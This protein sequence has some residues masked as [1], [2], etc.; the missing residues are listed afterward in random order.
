MLDELKQYISSCGYENIVTGTL[1][2]PQTQL[3]VIC[4]NEWDCTVS[5]INDGTGVHYIRIH[6]RRSVYQDAQDVCKELFEKLDSGPDETLFH[7]TPDCFC[8]AR[9]LRGP[10]ISEQGASSTTFYC[11]LALWG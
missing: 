3:N 8:I 11:E 10:L 5:E 2:D 4:V 9:P 1:P 6:V 7:L